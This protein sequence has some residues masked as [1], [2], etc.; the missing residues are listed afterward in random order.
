VF[1]SLQ[2]HAA[3]SVQCTKKECAMLFGSTGAGKSTLLHLLAGAKFSRETVEVGRDDDEY[4]TY[5][6]QQ[7]VTD[8]RIPGCEIGHS[9][10]SAT[11]LLSCYC[12][13][14]TKLTYVDTP[15]FNNVGDGDDDDTTIDAAN[16]AA[17]MR[18]IRSCGT[19]RIVFLISVQDQLNNK[20]GGQIKKLFE[21]M[22]KFIKDASHH[23]PSVLML[24]THC[25]GYPSAK[26]GEEQNCHVS[27][28]LVQSSS[29]WRILM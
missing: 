16:S 11:R 5:M 6:D 12:D 18:T 4:G 10:S 14:T 15:G 28:S 19:L 26:Q 3:G 17:I 22:D 13:D 1:A 2:E 27:A 21:V 7:L 20:R 29:V 8:M 25:D 9:R 24:F 23:L